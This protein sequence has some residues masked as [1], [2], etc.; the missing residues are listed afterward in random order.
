MKTNA[1]VQ[2]PP[3]TGGAT[4]NTDNLERTRELLFGPALREIEK[5]FSRLEERLTREISETKEEFRRRL[6]Q[7]EV[8]TKGELESLAQQ[9]AAERDERGRLLKQLS[10]E[11]V[12]ADNSLEEKIAQHVESSGRTARDLASQTRDQHRLLAEEL[13]QKFD[14]LTGNLARESAALRDDKTDRAALA[15]M[16][17]EMALRL[18]REVPDLPT[19]AG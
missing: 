13:Q 19:H 9:L 15:D 18:R 11:R 14:S 2:D 7:L 6:G 3:S 5:R 8:H 17:S 1:P 16:L 4:A 10:Q 12:A